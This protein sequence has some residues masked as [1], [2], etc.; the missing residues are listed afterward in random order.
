MADLVNLVSQNVKAVRQRITSACDRVG[1]D[2]STVRLVGVSKT[3]PI[4]HVMAAV[5]AGVTD[6]GENRVQEAEEKIALATHLTGIT[7][8][9]IGHL[10]S[11][12]ARRAISTMTWI[13]SVDSLDLLHRL[14]RSAKEKGTSAQ[15]LLQVDLAREVTKHGASADVIH[16]LLTAGADCHALQ[17]RGLMVLPPWSTDPEQSRPYFRQLRRLRDQLIDTGVDQTMLGEL[18]MGMSHDFDVAIE[19][20]ATMIR[21]GRAIFGRRSSN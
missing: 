13:Q 4:K 9:L 6:L 17:I 21:V 12:K 7:W 8:H 16:Q 14:E 20:G 19:E 1:R 15:L 18:S 3:F 11:N 2:P 5:D 10:Q